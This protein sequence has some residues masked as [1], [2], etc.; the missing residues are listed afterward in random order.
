MNTRERSGS[1]VGLVGLCALVLLAGITATPAQEDAA[2]QKVAAI[3]QSLQQSMAAL[4]SYEW[5]ETVTVKLD[6][7]QKS[8][9]QNRVYYGADGKQHKVPIGDQSSSDG[10]KKPRGLR[11]RIASAK[12]KEMEEYIQASMALVKQY[13]PTD[14]ERI[15]AVKDKG[16]DK[17][18]VLNNATHLR[19]TFPDY[20]KAGDAV[21]VDVDPKSDRITGISVSSYLEGDQKDVVKLNV[22]FSTFKDGTIYP[23]KITL[24]GDSKDLDVGIENSGYRKTGS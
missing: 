2:S 1:R 4:Q 10:G 15:Q 23:E 16:T 20:L 11:G 6:G 22:A 7:E 13:I 18:E 12:K 21:I 24:R 9:K 17:L 3:K 5:I 19:V 14:P 8:Q